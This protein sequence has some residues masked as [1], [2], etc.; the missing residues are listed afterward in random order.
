[1]LEIK[2]DDEEEDVLEIAHAGEDVMHDDFLISVPNEV[3]LDDHIFD[4]CIDEDDLDM[5]QDDNI[6]HGNED[7]LKYA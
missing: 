5:N 6:C 2:I 1:M 4:Q 7:K 3:L